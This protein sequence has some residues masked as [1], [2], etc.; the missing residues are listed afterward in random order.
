M[1]AMSHLLPQTMLYFAFFISTL[2]FMLCVSDSYP[3]FTLPRVHYKTTFLPEL[4]GNHYSRISPP[5]NHEP[6]T[7][8]ILLNWS[9]LSNVVLQ[10]SVYCS[11]Q[12]ADVVKHVLVWNNKPDLQ[13]EHEKAGVIRFTAVK[14]TSNWSLAFYKLELSQRKIDR[15]QLG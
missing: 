8:I 11:A 10:V 9:R 14:A 4:D 12:L 1:T 6:D 5:P 2:F 3:T 15:T 7:T 13:L